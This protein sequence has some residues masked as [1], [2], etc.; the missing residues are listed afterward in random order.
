MNRH[1]I[2]ACGDHRRKQKINIIGVTGTVGKRLA[3][4]EQ[5]TLSGMPKK[6]PEKS[7]TLVTFKKNLEEKERRDHGIQWDLDVQP[8][9]SSAKWLQL[10]GLKRNKLTFSQILSQIGFQHKEDYVS[11]LGKLVASRYANGLYRQYMTAPDGKLY[12]LTAKKDLLFH[13]VDC[14]TGAIELYKQRMEWLTTESRQIFGVIQEQSIT[15]VLDF[16]VASRA[17]FDLC[18]EALFMVFKQQVAQISKFNLI[19]VGQD[20]VKWQKETVPVTEASID[21]AVKWLWTMDYMP[22][23]C[24]TGPTEAILEALFDDTTDA[25]YYFIVGDLQECLKH[26]LL[27]KISRSP[28]PVHTVSFNAREEE[29]IAFLKELSHLTTGRFHA[30]VERTDYMDVMGTSISDEDEKR[31]LTQNSRKL[32]GDLPLGAGVREDVYLIWKELEEARNTLIQVQRI[33]I[34]FEQSESLSAAKTDCSVSEPKAK[35]YVNSKE[36]LQKNGLKAQKLTIS[37]AFADLAFRHAD[38]IVD[39]KTK[40]E[41]ESFQTDAET[42]KKIIHAK[43]CDKFM[44]TLLEDGSIVH[45]HLNSEKCRQYEDKMKNALDQMER[46]LQELRK[47]SRALFGEV[48]EDNIY[49]LIDTSQSMRD[50]LPVVKQKIFQL[51]QEQLQNKTKFNL[52]KFDNE[53]V[54]WKEKLAIVNE[55]NLEDAVLWVKGLEVGNSTNTLKALQ[56]AFSDSD[57][58]TIY[59]LTDGRPDQPPYRILA[60]LELQRNIPVHTVSFN[61]DDTEANKFLHA[62]ASKTGGRFHYY[63]ICLR[64]PDAPKPFEWEDIYLLKKEIERGE[65][66]LKKIQTFCTDNVLMDLFN[67]AKGRHDKH[68]RQPFTASTVTTHVEGLNPPSPDRPYW[69]SEAPASASPEPG[70]DG[71]E[72][73]SESPTRKKKALYAEQTKSSML[74][75]QRYASKPTE[76]STNGRASPERKGTATEEKT[77]NGNKKINKDPLDIPSAQWLKTHGLVA[78]R[79]TIMDALAPTAIPRTTKYIPILDKHVVSKVFDDVLPFAHVSNNKKIVTLINPQAVDLDAYKKKLQ[80]AIKVYERR[81]DQIIWRA[82]PQEEKEKFEQDRPVS[83]IER[84]ESLLQA[85][86]N[87]SWP[88]AYEDVM[89]LEDEILTGLTYKEQ[90]S[91]LQ[92]ASK[93]EPQRICPLRIFPTKEKFSSKLQAKKQKGKGVDT[94]KGQRVIARSES[95]GFYYP[96]TV[97]RSITP[98]Y[99]LVDFINGQTEIVPLK[100]IIPVGGA[101]PCPSLQVGD[102]VFIRVRKQSGDEHYVP[103]VVIAMP[104]KTDLDDKLYTVL[105]YNNRKAHCVRN[106]LI[107]ISLRR[108]TCSCCYINMT[109]MMDYL[110]PNIKVAKHFHRA[111]PAEE[112]ERKTISV[113]GDR[114]KRNRKGGVKSKEFCK[115]WPSSNSD[116]MLVIPRRLMRLKESNSSPSP[117]CKDGSAAPTYRGLPRPHSPRGRKQWLSSNASE[118]RLPKSLRC[119]RCPSMRQQ[120]AP[121]LVSNTFSSSSSSSSSSNTSLSSIEKVEELARRLQQYHI[122][123]KKGRPASCK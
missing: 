31:L 89:L 114:K 33:M 118:F 59:L 99:A 3:R 88:I 9:I 65:K 112:R 77:Q 96:G 60:Q 37:K 110:I 87:A 82:L 36:W 102:Y 61:C 41:D 71:C 32:K 19:R 80:E 10:H 122:A 51:M 39:I 2:H 28:C 69:A 27:Q 64:D 74:R 12:N 116:E 43:Y 13:F 100:F 38:G 44:Y 120:S 67:G 26:L 75:T 83:Y 50:K 94:L 103:G 5:V 30:F 16:G 25:V 73:R 66:E 29:T 90:A 20:L 105:K 93:E 53:A 15:I 97:I 34:E 84:K 52:V 42:N 109:R 78:R 107:K 86:E 104:Q 22:A 106:G 46:R 1:E 101:M 95:T 6:N 92:E 49:I 23:V 8:L 21:A 35:D 117:C 11:I 56:I 111:F 57:T 62:L 115:A 98:F 54:A 70:T 55:E 7:K 47:G 81:L 48:I 68:C 45:I 63:H 24:H 14:L 119:S 40:P 123:Q 4:N 72:A 113:G 85:L 76:R 79:L 121:Q 58:Q 18:K 91:E 17:E 108:Y